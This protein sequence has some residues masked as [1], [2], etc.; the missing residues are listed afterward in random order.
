LFLL[1]F[2]GVNGVLKSIYSK[3]WRMI[4]L[5]EDHEQETTLPWADAI[6]QAHHAYHKLSSHTIKSSFTHAVQLPPSSSL[7]LLD[8]INNEQAL[9]KQLEQKEREENPPIPP[10]RSSNRISSI[11][12]DPC[13]D[14]ASIA[15]ALAHEFD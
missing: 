7:S 14:D 9:K 5:F 1:F 8:L 15:Y 2:L 3:N 11:L 4:R 13:V 6:K 12:A 10:S